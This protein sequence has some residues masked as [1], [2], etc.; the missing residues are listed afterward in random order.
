MRRF[1]TLLFSLL[2]CSL[3]VWTQ[4][5]DFNPQSPPEPEQPAMRLDLVVSPAEAGSASGSG[6]YAPGKKVSINTYGNEGFRFENWTNSAGEVVSTTRSFTYTKQEGHEKLTAN[7]VFDPDSPADPAEPSTIMYFRLT[8]V[9]T[10]GGSVSGG[11][12]YLEGQQVTLRASCESQ[13]DFDGWYDAW[14][15]KLSDAKTFKYTTTAHHTMLTGRFIFNPNN[16]SEP[17]E[18]TLR[19]K[20]TITASCTEGGTIGWTSMRLQEGES[21]SFQASA[22]S[23]YDF[24]GWYKNGEL[25]TQ[26]TRFSYTVTNEAEQHFEARFIFN[27]DSPAEPQAPSN[28]KHSFYLMNK[29]TTPGT[30]IKFPVYLSNVRPLRDIS[31]QLTFPR[32][33][34]PDVENIVLSGRAQ[35]YNISCTKESETNDEVTYLLTLTGG[36]VG[37]GNAALIT[38]SVDVPEDIA[39]AQNYPVKINQVSVVEVKD[40]G[41]TERV[42]A[43][44][45]NGRISVY[46]LGDSNGDDDIN[47]ADLAGVSLF[48]MDKPEDKLIFPSADMDGNEII[49]ENDYNILVDSVLHQRMTASMAHM[50]PP[51][52]KGEYSNQCGLSI[53]DLIVSDMEIEQGT[54]RIPIQ[55]TSIETVTGFQFDLYLQEGIEVTTDENGDY[56]IDLYKSDSGDHRID[57]RQI[58]DDCIR[59]I[60]SS[61]NNIPFTGSYGDVM[62]LTVKVNNSPETRS[63]NIGIKNIVMT[64]EHADALI[65]EDANGTIVIVEN[66]PADYSKTEYNLSE[67]W[68]WISSNLD[69]EERRNIKTFLSNIEEDVARLLSQTSE[70]INDPACGLVGNLTAIELGKGYKLKMKRNA[71]MTKM[72]MAANI[73][74]LICLYKGWNWLGYLPKRRLSIETALSQLQPSEGDRLIAEDGFVE[75]CNGKWNG[76]IYMMEPG[77]GYMYY[78]VKDIEFMYSDNQDQQESSQIVQ[79]TAKK[80]YLPQTAETG[81]WVNWQYD[82]HAFPDNMTMICHILIDGVPIDMNDIVAVGAFCGEECRG[83]GRWV[84]NKLFLTIHGTTGMNDMVSLKACDV[85][86]TVMT[87]DEQFVFNGQCHGAFS[88]PILLHIQFVDK[89]STLTESPSRP[90]LIFSPEGKQLKKPQKGLNIVILPDGTKHKLLK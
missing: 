67:G 63:Y 88:N 72:D 38:L 28:T 66:N 59:F 79:Q 87:I 19:P 13:F 32:L 42:T 43:S 27:P 69:N 55:L 83:L 80:A 25:Y 70:V 41:T 11:G 24:D 61:M 9:A 48:M 51:L 56:V 22:N 34:L 1:L 16:P 52:K 14:G 85:N 29:E 6:R 86:G 31:F 3:P 82:F 23:G 71:T 89:I 90:S 81:E 30:T 47:V 7:Y 50:R 5:D 8:L 21:C 39:T 20:H 36:E 53:Q 73:D 15:N 46:K 35:N 58:T 49:E 37:V 76:D 54:I 65:P 10:E 45:R 33:L 77:K 26:L 17:T 75:Y 18:P 40:D 84:D 2:L 74:T 68:N 64:N 60:C 57:V 44:T 12:S 62:V 78:A 4:D